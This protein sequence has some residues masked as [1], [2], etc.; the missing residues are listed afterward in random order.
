MHLLFSRAEAENFNKLRIPLLFNGKLTNKSLE[1]CQKMVE[2]LAWLG[3]DL[4][5]LN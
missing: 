3:S 2:I 5:E 1:L 4:I